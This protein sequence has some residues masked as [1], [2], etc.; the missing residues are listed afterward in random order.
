[1][2]ISEFINVPI[3]NRN[4]KYYES[5][6]YSIPKVPAKWGKNKFATPNGTK[7]LV[8]IKDLPKGSNIM[9]DYQCDYCGLKD[10]KEYCQLLISRKIVNTDCCLN[11]VPLKTKEANLIKYGVEHTSELESNKQK[12]KETN[13][14]VY[15]SE[16]A[17]QNKKVK[18]KMK[19]TFLE[20]YGE[21]TPAKNQKVKDKMTKTNLER[22]G[23]ISPTLNEEVRMKQIETLKSNYGVEFPQQS[24]DIKKLSMKALYEN[25][26]APCSRQQK[27][28]HDLLGGELNFPHN[29]S[30]LDIAFVDEMVYLE[31][32]LGGHELPM[33][34]GNLTEEDYRNNERKRWYALYRKGWKEIRIISSKDKVPSDEKLLEMMKYANEY[35]NTGRHY[36]KF[37]LDEGKVKTSQFEKDYDFGKLRYIYKK[38]IEII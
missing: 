26:T 8:E 34:L 6:G 10:Q 27:Y 30:F 32:D 15:G 19:N 20:K 33:K 38:D 28:I 3:N 14:K 36:I 1:L 35:L 16:Y 21:I 29:N 23:A 7:I 12:R 22:Y 4:L 24:D 37:Y 18:E 31:I 9:V 5:L 2:I 11:C 25:Q 17:V 13:L